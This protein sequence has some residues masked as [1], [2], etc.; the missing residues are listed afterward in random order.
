MQYYNL[1]F[2]VLDTNMQEVYGNCIM[3]ETE[4]VAYQSEVHNFFSTS[5]FK[6]YLG[7]HMI[8]YTCELEFWRYIEVLPISNEEKDLLKKLRLDDFG[9]FPNIKCLMKEN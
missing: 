1:R 7:K 6:L 9:F 5:D 4:F 8:R 3:S 2:V